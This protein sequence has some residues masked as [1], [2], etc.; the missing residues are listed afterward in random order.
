MSAS[1]SPQLL[2]ELRDARSARKSL[3]TSPSMVDART[4]PTSRSAKLLPLPSNSPNLKRFKCTFKDVRL[5]ELPPDELTLNNLQKAIE[6]KFG[7]I[8]NLVLRFQDVEGDLITVV[9][10]EDLDIA[11]KDFEASE[12]VLFDEPDTVMSW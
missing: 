8:F 9:T 3:P 7:A 6:K 5:I 10:Q 1:F 11:I 2:E 12:F 4:I